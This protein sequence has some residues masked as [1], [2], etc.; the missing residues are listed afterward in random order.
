MEEDY[1]N[2]PCFVLLKKIGTEQD[3]WRAE[4]LD[5]LILLEH[6]CLY[7]PEKVLLQTLVH[8]RLR[9]MDLRLSDLCRMESI[10]SITDISSEKVSIDLA[11][12][13]AFTIKGDEIILFHFCT[14]W[15]ELPFVNRVVLRSSAFRKYAEVEAPYPESRKKRTV[16]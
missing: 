14:V 11:Y 6:I 16:Y 10:F 5:A 7:L 4:N 2:R 8:D 15:K 12:P 13:A 1:N 9:Y 3:W